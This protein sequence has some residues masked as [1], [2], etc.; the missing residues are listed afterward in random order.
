MK[1][2]PTR[3]TTQT[4]KQKIRASA[5]THTVPV[6]KLVCLLLCLPQDSTTRPTSTRT[7]QK[8]GRK[9]QPWLPPRRKQQWP[10]QDQSSCNSSRFFFLAERLYLPSWAKFPIGKMLRGHFRT[11][12]I[13][14]HAPP[15]SNEEPVY[16]VVKKKKK[17]KPPSPQNEDEL[18]H[19][20]VNVITS[21]LILFNII[22]LFTPETFT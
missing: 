11:M 22:L 6:L 12:T 17:K 5:V 18:E 2:F 16:A 14:D 9:R 10:S 4:E 8:E 15:P 13:S 20:R 21:T 7:R 3:F 1:P 19:E